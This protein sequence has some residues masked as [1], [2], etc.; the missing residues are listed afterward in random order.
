MMAARGLPEGGGGEGGGG[1]VKMM[2]LMAVIPSKALLGKSPALAPGPIA[3]ITSGILLSGTTV[4]KAD[5]GDM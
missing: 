1:A 3:E 2:F 4:L 5:C